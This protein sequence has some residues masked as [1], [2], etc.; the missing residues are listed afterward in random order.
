M[1]DVKLTHSLKLPVATSAD[2][3]RMDWSSLMPVSELSGMPYVP[4]ALL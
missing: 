1:Y 2:I 4:G 3:A